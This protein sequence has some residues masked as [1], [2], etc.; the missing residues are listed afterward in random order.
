MNRRR[1]LQSGGLAGVPL[2]AAQSPAKKPLLITSA[3][4]DL[5]RK[6]AAGLSA[7]HA[8]RLTERKA[9]RVEHEFV[10]CPLGHD[11]STNDAVRG[12]EAIVH[13]AEPLPEDR[14]EQQ[15]DLTTRCTY[16]LLFAAAAEGVPLVVMLSTLDVMGGY[17]A[18]LTV[19]ETWRP[20][21]A[22]EPRVLA[23]HLGEFTSREF[24]REGKV[25]VVVLR[26]GKVVRSEEVTDRP[27]D[28]LWVDE[29]DVVHAVSLALA[30]KLGRFQVF[31]IQSDS[32]KA[33]FAVT[34][35]TRALKYRP[36][37]QW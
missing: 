10:E 19:T 27:F 12:V 13:V 26:L 31:H 34:R 24:A 25:N 14:A 3:G 16:N 15:I 33:R 32:P 4:S 29:R 8:I 9:V 21:P 20:T 7:Q 5:A 28:P 17:D 1:F 23:K 36:Q 22:A 30:S 35:A 11:S 2:A 37:H 6:L 18:N